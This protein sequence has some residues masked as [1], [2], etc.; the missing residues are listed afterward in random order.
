MPSDLNVVLLAGGVGGAKLAEG[1]CRVKGVELSIIC[2]VGDDDKFHGLHVSPDVDTML[3]TLSNRI[4]RFQGWGVKND[5]YLALDVL[6]ELGNQTWMSLGDKDFG[7]HIYRS[8]RLNM[9]DPLSQI[10]R[11]IEKVF[12]IPAKIIVPT[13]SFVPTRVRIEEGWITF[14]EYF[15]MRKCEP[16]ILDLN[17]TNA[18]SAEP[19]Q[20]ALQV[21]KVADVIVLAPS[22]PL[23]SL[24]PI[25]EIP[26]IKSVVMHDK[27]I[28]K[29]AVSPLI[30]GKAVKGPVEKILREMGF[31]SNTSTIVEFF[32][33]IID[34]FILDEQ[35]FNGILD[36]PT[37]SIKY[38]PENILMDSA[39]S[40][41]RVAETVI[42]KAREF[43]KLELGYE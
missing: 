3:Y 6:R 16:R 39:Q 38:Y 23:L 31:S 11:D 24:L 9:G 30:A 4:N 21:L 19:N 42:A 18:T 25:L 36:M 15:V 12:R 41:I 33:D 13:N 27:R 1:L 32:Q 28:P 7:L 17:Y 8:N 14:Q 20:E 29:V 43:R 37:S 10:T 35:D 22:N 34:I 2:N 26:Q 40:K 5:T